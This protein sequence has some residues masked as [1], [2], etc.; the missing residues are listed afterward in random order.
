MR[1]KVYSCSLFFNEFSLLELKLETLYDLVD[2]FV[3]SESNITHSGDSKPFLLEE[4][5]ERFEKYRDKIIYQK[6]VDTPNN[7]VDLPFP[8]P[9][10]KDLYYSLVVQRIRFGD[11]WDH[12]IASY[13][14]DTFEKE[15]LI[16]PLVGVRKHDIILLSDLDEIVRPQALEEIL[17]S[18]DENETYHF[19]HDMFYYF[20]NLQTDEPWHGTIALTMKKFLEKSF[21]EMRTRKE[22]K[23][24]S[25]GGWHF[26]FM[27]GANAIK[28]KI[29]S[30]GEQSLNTVGVINNI[31]YAMIN[32]LL[33]G[34]DLFGRP[35]NFTVRDINDGTFPRYLVNHQDDIFKG[36]IYGK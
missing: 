29:E 4:N 33:H 31:P 26:S 15:S 19:Q 13:G 8:E 16:R 32:A 12:S 11:W 28:T 9:G 30:Y 3:I 14:R 27:G 2:Y 18:F 35:R 1:P 24:V 20:L 36:M 5:Y 10:V 34:R 23:F 7:F 22:G 21:C 17:N 25:N 6:L